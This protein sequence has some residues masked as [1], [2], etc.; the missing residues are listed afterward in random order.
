MIQANDLRLGNYIYTPGEVKAKILSI[1]NLEVGTNY[2]TWGIHYVDPIQLTWDWLVM[3][4]FTDND[5]IGVFINGKYDLEELTEGSGQWEFCINEIQTG[6]I[7]TYV[8]QLQ[9]LY[10]ALTGQELTVKP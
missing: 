4:G 10:Y 2:G 3:F 7:L 6:T 9:N 1:H 8:H 5:R